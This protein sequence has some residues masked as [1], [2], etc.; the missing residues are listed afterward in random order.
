MLMPPQQPGSNPYD[1]ITNP[2]TPQKKGF[3]FGGLSKPMKLVLFLGVLVIVFGILA[4]ILSSLSS[5]NSQDLMALGTT[6]TKIIAIADIGTQKGRSTDT[7]NYAQTLKQ[8]M[9]TDNNLLKA[10]LAKKKVKLSK[11]GFA[12]D[13]S[14]TEA[15]LASAE[16]NNS[17][18]ETFKKTTDELI[19]EYQ[20]ELRTAFSDAKSRSEKQVLNELNKTIVV[21]K[22]PAAKQN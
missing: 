9:T 20:N 7:K 2:Q 11:K 12:A 21:I 3:A 19:A 13:T 16:Q 14:K 1:F 4:I 22:P 10:L 17:F 6:Q 8:S 18:D 5:E 15:L